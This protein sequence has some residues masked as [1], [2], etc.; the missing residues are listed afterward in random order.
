MEDV[1]ARAGLQRLFHPAGENTRISFAPFR[2]GAAN[3]A[4]TADANVGGRTGVS[5]QARALLPA[6]PRD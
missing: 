3:D 4:I 1:P 2:A 5:R 6:S